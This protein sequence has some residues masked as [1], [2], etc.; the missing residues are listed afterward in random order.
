MEVV[1]ENGEIV[2]DTK[3]V[4]DRWMSDFSGLYNRPRDQSPNHISNYE[5]NRNFDLHDTRMNEH[6]S[7][8]EV[9]KA[10][11]DAKRNKAYGLDGI[12]A[13]VLKG[14]CNFIFH[15]CFLTFALT[16]E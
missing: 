14:L 11:H 3:L 10:V 6:I 2:N 4:L 16:K 8:F 15:M 12:P 5:N 1:S 7:I 13:D 9:K